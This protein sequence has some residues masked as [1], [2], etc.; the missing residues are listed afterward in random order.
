MC[1]FSA[2]QLR[3]SMDMGDPGVAELVSTAGVIQLIVAD[4]CVSV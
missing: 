4:A 1:T 2:K 3:I